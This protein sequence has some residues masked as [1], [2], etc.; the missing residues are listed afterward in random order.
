MLRLVEYANRGETKTLTLLEHDNKLLHRLAGPLKPDKP[1]FLLL[2]VH[3]SSLKSAPAKRYPV[4]LMSYD[5]HKTFHHQTT[6]EYD[7]LVSSIFCK[8]L[9]PC[10]FSYPRFMKSFHLILGREFGHPVND[11]SLLLIELVFH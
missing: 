8:T 2:S 9:M 7:E 10:S 1:D 6:G 3:A 5:N 11:V 4:T